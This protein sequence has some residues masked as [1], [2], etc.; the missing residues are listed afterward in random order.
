MKFTF[1]KDRFWIAGLLCAGVGIVLF[2]VVAR[3]FSQ[4]VFAV[5]V[6]LAGVTLALAGLVIILFGISNKYKSTVS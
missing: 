3:L 4:P 5:V 2:K 1:L 6:F